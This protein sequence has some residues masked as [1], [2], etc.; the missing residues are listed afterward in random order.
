MHTKAGAAQVIPSGRSP[1][2]GNVRLRRVIGMRIAG[3]I[4]G[5]RNCSP[6][7]HR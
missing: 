6:M 1:R 3:N 2:S 7:E 4:G 5:R